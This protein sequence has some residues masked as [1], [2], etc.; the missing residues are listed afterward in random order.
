MSEDENNTANS[1]CMKN[2]ET[3]NGNRKRNRDSNEN[4]GDE[5]QR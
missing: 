3:T 4:I 1:K 5:N 2:D